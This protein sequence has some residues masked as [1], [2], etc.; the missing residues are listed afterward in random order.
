MRTQAKVAIATSLV[1]QH[2]APYASLA[3][4]AAGHDASPLLL[5]SQ[6]ADHTR[7]LEA[8]PR[9]SLLFDGTAGLA[10]P[11]TGARA[12]IQGKAAPTDDRLLLDR[13]V[14]RHPDAAVYVGFSDFRLFRIEVEAAHLVAGFGRIHWIGAGEIIF[15]IGGSTA[16]AG[17]ETAVVEHMNGDHADAVD[18]YARLAGATNAGWTMTGIDPEGADLRREGEILRVPFD[19]TANDAEGARRELVRLVRRARNRVES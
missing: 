16:L 18:L 2:A 15:D 4:V 12:S 13:F 9:I 19:E 6:L 10:S 14:R 3:I 11:L 5:L 7:N 17:D 1:R 8:D